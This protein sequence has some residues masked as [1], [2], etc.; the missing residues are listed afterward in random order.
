MLNFGL[1]WA[2]SSCFEMLLFAYD[3]QKKEI[4]QDGEEGLKFAGF[5]FKPTEEAKDR[6][7]EAMDK[8]LEK[9]KDFSRR[10]AYNDDEDRTYVN[11]RN[12]FFNK[13]LDRF[14]GDYTEAQNSPHQRDRTWPKHRK[15]HV[16][17][18]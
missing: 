2:A 14:F 13:K 10:R 5:G 17:N 4:E 11:D 3:R 16:R 7:G 12:R 9:K 8:I 15:F 1:L 6:L 18:L